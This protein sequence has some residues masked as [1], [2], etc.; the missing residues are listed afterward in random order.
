MNTTANTSHAYHDIYERYVEEASFLWM[1]RSIAVDQPHYTPADVQVVDNRVQT[2]LDGLITSM[3]TAWEVCEN[4]LELKGPGEI[5]AAATVAFKSHDAH[6]IQKVVDA[7]LATDATFKGLISAIAWLPSKVSYPWIQKFLTSKDINHKYL[8]ISLCSLR[9][10]N[11]GEFL[12]KFLKRKDCVQHE[13]LYARCL[14]LIGELKRQDLISEI[15]SAETSDN[16]TVKFWALWSAVLLGNKENI[17]NMEPY[18]FNAS[19]HQQR[20]LDITFRVLPIAQARS[21]ISR[22]S[23]DKDH[24]R[25]VIKATGIL[26]DPH[27]VDWLILKMRETGYARLAAESFTLITGI[28]LEIKQLNQDAPEQYHPIPNQNADD[29]TVAMDD[30]ENLPWPNP[31]LVATW[32][33]QYG[34]QFSKGQRYLLGKENTATNLSSHLQHAYQRQRHAAALEL[35]LIDPGNVLVNT[36][37][38]VASKE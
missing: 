10:E 25:S 1:M 36:R 6:K 12:D 32:W 4:A 33:Q 17:T 22:L 34:N 29:D 21:L 9:R 3:D 13:K 16:A 15:K 8:A 38:K 18:I 31:T 7:G 24:M 27:A 28:D 26:G 5:F 23:S 30:D 35:A 19:P 37:F 11:P 20:A 2:Q 14:R